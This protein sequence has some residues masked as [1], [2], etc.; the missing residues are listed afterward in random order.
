M[1]QTTR[2]G[3]GKDHHQKS[4]NIPKVIPVIRFTSSLVVHKVV[5]S[6]KEENPEKEIKE[7]IAIVNHCHHHFLHPQIQKRHWLQVSESKLLRD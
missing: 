1:Q 6:G 3:K 4:P 2:V 5:P 7:S